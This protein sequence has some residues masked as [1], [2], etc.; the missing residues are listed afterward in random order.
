MFQ[1]FV[2]V[3]EMYSWLPKCI[4]CTRD[5]E[6]SSLFIAPPVTQG[7]ANGTQK[8]SIE[9]SPKL[10]QAL[11]L[12]FG[13]IF[14]QVNIRALF[15]Y[16]A[17]KFAKC[18]C[19]SSGGCLNLFWLWCVSKNL[20]F[21]ISWLANKNVR[22]QKRQPVGFGRHMGVAQYYSFFTTKIMHV[23]LASF[24]LGLIFSALISIR[25]EGEFSGGKFN[26][27][28]VF[29]RCDGM[30]YEGEFRDGKVCGQGLF[31]NPEKESLLIIR[32][33]IWSG[34]PEVPSG[35]SPSESESTVPTTLPPTCLSCRIKAVPSWTLMRHAL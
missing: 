22:P 35:T 6:I 11:S 33:W 9:N 17:L 32:K 34:S 2:T 25:Y 27:C 5:S 15:F 20:S 14:Q 26:G 16:W 24:L 29:I 8:K 3:F 31:L 7:S 13:M 19:F 21:E 12:I 1:L 4:W 10:Q 28:G 18:K 30:K 23:M